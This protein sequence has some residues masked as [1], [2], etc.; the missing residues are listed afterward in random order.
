MVDKRDVHINVYL[1]SEEH[2][3][4]KRVAAADELPLATWARRAL[5]KAATKEEAK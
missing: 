5:L 2:D 1:R 4:L 3:L